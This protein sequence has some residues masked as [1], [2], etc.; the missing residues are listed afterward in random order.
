MKC[1]PAIDFNLYLNYFLCCSYKKKAN[2]GFELC[3]SP[4]TSK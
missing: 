2:M 3:V 4:D 1:F